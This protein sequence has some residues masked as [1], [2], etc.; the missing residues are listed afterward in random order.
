M[1]NPNKNQ[2]DLNPH[3]MTLGGYHNQGYGSHSGQGS[4]GQPQPSNQKTE[5]FKWN[6]FTGWEGMHQNS[7]STSNQQGQGQQKSWVDDWK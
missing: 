4:M 5:E 3:G 7:K 2:Q 1:S 6:D